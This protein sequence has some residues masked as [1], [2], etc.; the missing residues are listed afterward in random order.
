MKTQTEVKAATVNKIISKET[1]KALGYL[2]AS[3]TTAGVYYEVKFIDHKL[4][5]NCRA[6]VNGMRCCHL[7][8]VEEVM[9]ERRAARAAAQ[10]QAAIIAA[11][12]A[13][14]ASEVE[15]VAHAL[16][17]EQWWMMMRAG[18]QAAMLADIREERADYLAVAASEVET[19]DEA[20]S[21]HDHSY[22]DAVLGTAYEDIA[23]LMAQ[24]NAIREVPMG[25]QAS[26]EVSCG[27]CGGR[28]QSWNCNL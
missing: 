14:A 11:Y 6:A 10:A 15:K 21:H 2:V 3:N 8:A 20:A 7:R 23:L 18:A 5:C 12:L 26:T 4:T 17:F 22:A 27:Y 28:H 1:G 24:R 9:H 13:V 19:K 25:I 16:D